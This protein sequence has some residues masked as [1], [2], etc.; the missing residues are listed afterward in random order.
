MTTATTTPNDP[1]AKAHNRGPMTVEEYREYLQGYD[2]QFLRCRD[3][4]HLWDI[5]EDY[6]L[7]SD[8]WV[9]RKMKCLRCE[10]MRTEIFAIVNNQ[11]LVKQS[12]SYA[13]PEG[14]Q[15]HGLPSARGLSEILRYESLRRSGVVKR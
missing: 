13:Y 12:T 7:R 1:K 3:L 2:G 14:Y 4:R 5:D 11:R 15:T 10:T 6:T 8:G 9:T